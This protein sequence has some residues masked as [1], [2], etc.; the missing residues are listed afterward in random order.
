MWLEGLGKLKNVHL[1]H[2]ESNLWPFG[3]MGL[4]NGLLEPRM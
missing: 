2:Q 4:T 3:L 1:H